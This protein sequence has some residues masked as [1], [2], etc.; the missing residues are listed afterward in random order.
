M[1]VAA[2][3]GVAVAAAAVGTGKM[4]M[5]VETE[6]APKNHVDQ[7]TVKMIAKNNDKSSTPAKDTQQQSSV[8]SSDNG[9]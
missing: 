8:R 3:G 1:V 7:M 9:K 4:M 6:Q 2:G 5:A